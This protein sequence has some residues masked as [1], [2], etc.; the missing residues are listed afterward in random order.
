M[1]P[2]VI[3]RC[4]VGAG[5]SV[6]VVG[7]RDDFF[8][9]QR[10][11]APEAA[12]VPAARAKPPGRNRV[13]AFISPNFGCRQ[14][15]HSTGDQHVIGR[16]SGS[17][18]HASHPSRDDQAQRLRRG[19]G[20]LCRAPNTH[21]CQMAPENLSTLGQTIAPLTCEQ[22]RVSAA[23]RSG[24]LRGVWAEPP[25]IPIDVH[26]GRGALRRSPGPPPVTPARACPATAACRPW[27]SGAVSPVV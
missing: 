26:T 18:R 13:S 12:G 15:D 25:R 6:R 24:L 1:K 27:L 9:R 20:G 14:P 8:G 19:A 3:Q 17:H 21:G 23:H 22:G 2:S 16:R 7:S 10:P 11:G 4:R 5:S